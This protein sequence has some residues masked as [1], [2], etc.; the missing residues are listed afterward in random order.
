MKYGPPTFAVTFA[1]SAMLVLAA[2]HPV[3]DKTMSTPGAT[4]APL[5]AYVADLQ[6]AYGPPSQAA[7]GS[8]VF[9]EPHAGVG[10]LPAWS[11]EKYKYFVGDLWAR[12]GE[13]TWLGP[14]RQV[15]VRPVD[16]TPDIVAEL[17]TI[18][19]PDAARS[20]PLILD[21]VDG[22]EQARAALAAAFD[23]PTMREVVVFNLG[24]GEA[25]SGLLVAGRRPD[26]GEAI[27]LVLLLD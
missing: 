13:A 1:L 24:D 3:V 16:T 5:P 17:R 26:S 7:F 10:D 19:D 4:D 14:W 22:A 21:D 15:Y 6:A 8:A 23:D 25:M 27:F 11:L 9:F 12:Y 2:C 18:D 20:V